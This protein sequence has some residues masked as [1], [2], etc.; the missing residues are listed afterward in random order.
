MAILMLLL[1]RKPND[2]RPGTYIVPHAT[3]PTTLQVAW[4][5]GKL[6]QH[7]FNLLM[8]R[9]LNTVVDLVT[10]LPVGDQPLDGE[11][12]TFRSPGCHVQAWKETK[13]TYGILAGAVRGIGE[14][15]ATWGAAPAE[16]LVL[17]GKERV[18]RVYIE[19]NRRP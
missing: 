16:I 2:Q 4:H 8:L 9:A 13:F 11:R 6:P 19:Q 12:I 14:L 7:E 15:M 17:V 3:F 5:Y 10:K 18:A 1:F